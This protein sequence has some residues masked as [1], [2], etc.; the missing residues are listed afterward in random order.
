MPDYEEYIEMIK[1]IWQSHR[2]TNMGFLHNQ[3]ENELKEYLNV[4]YVVLTTNGHTALEIAIQAMNLEGEVITT[5]F[6]FVSTIHAIVRSGLTPVFCDIDPETGTIDTDKV[7]DLI[8]PRTSAILPVHVYGNVCDVEKIDMIAKKHGLK[9]IYDAAHTFGER[10]KERSVVSYGDI[11]ILSF[12]A[13]KIFHTIEGGAVVCRTEDMKNKLYGLRNFGIRSEEIVDEI[14]TNSKM[15]E[16]RAAMGLCNL[17]KNDTEIQMRKGIV[18]LYKEKLGN[19]SGIDFFREQSDLEC[20]YAY[21]PVMFDENKLG[22]NRDFLYDFLKVNGIFARKYFY[23]LVNDLDAYKDYD[24]QVDVPVARRISKRVL[25]LPLYSSLTDE[26]VDYI[27][28]KILS[29][30]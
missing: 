21:F 26:D 4:P 24:L 23:P 18:E 13:T 14:G 5:P 25:T 28:S 29:F 22:Y 15:D 30:N 12:H 19:I 1:P 11:S 9:V 20:N 16:F 27:C 7:E 17:K 3:L 6:T 8:T 10:Y 2:L